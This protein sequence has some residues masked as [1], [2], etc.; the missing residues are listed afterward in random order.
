MA[1][2]R[3]V[4]PQESPV[5]PS[6][7]AGQKYP[8]DTPTAI[9]RNIQKVRN[10]SRNPS[11]RTFHVPFGSRGYNSQD[12]VGHVQQVEQ[13]AH[14]ED[15]APHNPNQNADETGTQHLAQDH[16]FGER[17]CYDGHHEG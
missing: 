5:I 9:A 6:P 10:L 1:M 4:V 15:T 13:V 3:E 2:G 16:E 11:R 12:Q 17:E 7:T 14:Q 8:M